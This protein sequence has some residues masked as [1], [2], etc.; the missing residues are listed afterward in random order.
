MIDKIIKHINIGKGFM[1][2]QL[3]VPG[4]AWGKCVGKLSILNDKNYI[5]LQTDLHFNR[6]LSSLLWETMQSCPCK[7]SH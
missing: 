2:E 5:S 3:N 6:M 7:S 4:V 1:V